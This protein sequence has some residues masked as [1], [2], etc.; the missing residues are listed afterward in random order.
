MKK[1]DVII[2]GAGV[3]GISTAIQLKRFGV[4]F[5]LLDKNKP[6]SHLRNAYLI[7]N[8]LGFPDFI[9]GEELAKLFISQL[10]KF[11]IPILQREVY[12]IG[13]LN[14]EFVVYSDSEKYSSKFLVLATGSIPVK[15]PFESDRIFYDIIK[16]K[17]VKNKT[18]TVIGSGDVAFDYA[19]SLSMENNVILINRSHNCKCINSLSD[20]VFQNTNIRYL[21]NYK[22]INV[23]DYNKKIIL[24]FK[25]KLNNNILEITSDYLVPAIGRKPNNLLIEKIKKYK[26]LYLAGD[27]RNPKFRQIAIASGDGIKVAMKIFKELKN[28]A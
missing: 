21:Y 6:C 12:K 28:T 22:L 17:K 15:I 2:I 8:Y 13:F 11:H 23:L 3:A 5:L 4:S 7:E 14:N 10:K 27:V 1:F 18:I 25:H 20:K 24:H 26:G 19:L 16:L 9:Y